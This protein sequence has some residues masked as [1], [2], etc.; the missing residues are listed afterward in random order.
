MWRILQHH[1]ADDWVL[2]TGEATSV[3][4]FVEI[5]FHKLGIDITWQGNG[6]REIGIDQNER[7]LIEIDER[8]FRPT[9]VPHLLGDASKAKKELGW[10]PKYNLNELIDEMLSENLR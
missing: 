8:Y 1:E 9:E 7:V 5:V 10:K 6:L 3:R 2:A 4:K